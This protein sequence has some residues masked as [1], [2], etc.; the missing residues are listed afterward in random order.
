MRRRLRRAGLHLLIRI[1]AEPEIW[2]LLIARALYRGSERREDPRVPVGSPV[3][4]AG[5]TDASE[6]L[7]LDLSNRGCRLRTRAPLS[8]G[9]TIEFTIPEEQGE[10]AQPLAL[11]GTV[12]RLTTPS[13]PGAASTVAMLFDPTLSEHTRTRLTGLINHWASG[14][15]SIER[16]SAES[17]PAIPPCQLPSLP[18]LMLD[19][20]TDPPIAARHAVRVQLGDER[21][22]VGKERRA[23]PRGHFASA[24]EAI[25]D[26]G[27][28]VLIG[29][30]LSSGGMRIERHPD[31]AVGDRFQLALRGPSLGVP[32]VVDARVV[33]DDGVAGFVL[34][35]DAIDTIA[36]RELEKMVACLPEVES[37][38]DGEL[39]GMGAILSEII[40]HR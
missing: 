29:R 36:A 16:N 22:D 30:D 5:V 10:T 1:P 19:D 33:R 11:R 2:R 24:V 40:D 25:G 26:E 6:T 27:P 14:P 39:A 32:L 34:S 21:A 8:V 28:F 35:F 12:K 20:E 13:E 31:L 3:E 18:D 9:D 37:L 7:L 38:E 17:G 15:S 4:L 23:G